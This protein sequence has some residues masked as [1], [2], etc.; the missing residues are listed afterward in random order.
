MGETIAPAGAVGGGEVVDAGP[1]DFSG[2]A[3][4]LVVSARYLDLNGERVRIRGMTIAVSGLNRVSA[5]E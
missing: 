2:R 4:K 3:G 5:A 1:S